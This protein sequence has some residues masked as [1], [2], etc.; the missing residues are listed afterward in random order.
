MGIFKSILHPFASDDIKEEIKSNGVLQKE[1]AAEVKEAPDI[2]TP[3]LE[4]KKVNANTPNNGFERENS[5]NAQS[6][7]SAISD[8]GMLYEAV[9]EAILSSVIPFTGHDSF[10]GMNI[11]VKDEIYHVINEN[12]FILEIRA[13]FDS[14]HLYSLGKGEINVVYGEPNQND[15]A[16][17]ITKN[18]F[19]P[20][21]KLWMQIIS[22]NAKITKHSK[23]T[24]SAVPGM[25]SCKK[26]E[27]LLD[28]EVKTIYRIGRGAFSRKPGSVYRVNDIIIDDANP[29]HDIQKLNNYVSSA[30]A[31]IHIFNGDFY[32]KAMPSGCR[33]SGGSPT[34][35]IRDQAPIELR[36]SF[37][38]YRL[39]DGDFIE[40]G[41]SVLLQFKFFE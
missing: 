3:S 9:K 12:S 21:G 25:G 30:Q 40:L 13:A 1:D 39:K 26:N 7:T 35:I 14:M 17:A 5:K 6:S 11:W 34:K 10:C 38:S 24:I 2:N 29:E 41:K 19:I 20:S 18:G 15:Q 36:D 16:T 37:S 27:Y 28:S 31:D 22:K 4:G 33:A 32:L 8:Y 23:A